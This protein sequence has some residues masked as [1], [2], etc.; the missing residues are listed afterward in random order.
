MLLPWVFDIL[1]K[2]TA[3]ESQILCP[4]CGEPYESVAVEDAFVFRGHGNLPSGEPAMCSFAGERCL[5]ERS[6]APAPPQRSGFGTMDRAIGSQQPR[7]RR[8]FLST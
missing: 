3:R 1:D 4:V 2:W 6:T 5:T 8:S 7:N